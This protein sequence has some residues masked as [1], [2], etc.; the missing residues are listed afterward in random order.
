MQPNLAVIA[1]ARCIALVALVFVFS[2]SRPAEA[3]PP[4]NDTCA[5]AIVVTNVPFFSQ[6]V[7]VS[8]A[9][10]AGDPPLPAGDDFNQDVRRSVWYKFRPPTTG[11]YTFFVAYDTATIVEDTV[12]AVYTISDG[13]CAG[14]M[15]V[16]T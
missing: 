15:N 2:S 13:G 10:T 4:P 8:E 11:L 6:P 14:A 5:G 12:M 3:A 9:S 1:W 7:D 16:Y